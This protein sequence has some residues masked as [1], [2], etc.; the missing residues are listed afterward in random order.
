MIHGIPPARF[1]RELYQKTSEDNISDG[2]A[3][4]GFY[5]TL[6]IFP[7][8]IFVMAVI[9]YLPIPNVDRAIMDL[10]RQAMPASAADMV[11]EV[12]DEVANNQRGGLVSF[13]VL[14]TLVVMLT[15]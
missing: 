11:S 4:L 2:A 14:G 3:V 8:L 12:V 9:P 5:L 13:G 1:L 7:A 10:L 15:T 6:A